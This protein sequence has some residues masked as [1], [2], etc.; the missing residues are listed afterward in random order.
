MQTG[1]AIIHRQLQLAH[2]VGAHAT[3]LGLTEA[4]LQLRRGTIDD[5]AV[6]PHRFAKSTVVRLPRP[7][8]SVNSTMASF[9]A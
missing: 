7:G 4:I 3:R 9:T 1:F 2:G 8:A 6:S 5:G